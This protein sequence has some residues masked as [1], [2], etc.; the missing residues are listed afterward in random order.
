MWPVLLT[1]DNQS[2]A[3]A[4]VAQVGID[5]V[6]PQRGSTGSRGLQAE[7]PG[8]GHG[9]NGGQRRLCSGLGRLGL[10]TGTRSD[11]AIKGSDPTLVS[12]D[13][14]AVV[15]VLRLSRATLRMRA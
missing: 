4:V 13:L 12:G 6:L 3:R 9:G 11:V 15:D 10:T 5:E 8:G 14:V 2:S 7:S 1:A